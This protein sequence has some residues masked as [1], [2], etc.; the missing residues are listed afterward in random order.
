MEDTEAR[1]KSNLIKDCLHIVNDLAENDF[2]D[3]DGE[4]SKNNFDWEQLQ[5]LILKAR[6]LKRNRWWD[7]PKNKRK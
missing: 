2:G 3:I 5:D 1:E 6:R 4:F 7:V